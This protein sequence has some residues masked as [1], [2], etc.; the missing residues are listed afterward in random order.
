MC[1]HVF[2][3]GNTT[4]QTTQGKLE[5]Q[6]AVLILSNNIRKY[7]RPRKKPNTWLGSFLGGAAGYR[8]RVR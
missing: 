5:P 1:G 3:Q 8:P 6:P 4:L 2:G 7:I